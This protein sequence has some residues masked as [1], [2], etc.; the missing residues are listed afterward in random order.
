MK[1]DIIIFADNYVGE[2]IVEWLAKNFASEISLVFTTS[3]NRITS[4]CNQNNI[5]TEIFSDEGQALKVINE[6][7]VRFKIGFLIWWPKIITNNIIKI[8]KNGFVNTHPSFLPFARGKNYNFWSIVENCPFGVTLHL[9]E[10]GID[11]GDIVEQRE[12]EYGWTDTGGSLFIKAREEMISLFKDN[13]CSIR[14][15]RFVPKKQ[16]LSLG[17]LHYGK[18]LD[19]VC[20]IDL[21]QRY[22]A[23]DLINLLRART[24]NG[25]P[26]CYFFDSDKRYEIQIS[27]EE[28]G[29]DGD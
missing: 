16:N 10:E 26:G 19:K 25:Y 24:M 8:P 14:D 3:K 15:L 11:C 4:M 23:K 12:I 17:S 13:Y 2:R 28:V 20:E 22:L 5:R 1:D 29:T 9:V 6:S 7:K 21:D 27:I 18:E